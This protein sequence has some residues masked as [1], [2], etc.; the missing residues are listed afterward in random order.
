[1]STLPSSLFPGY[2]AVY[3]YPFKVFQVIEFLS[4][5]SDQLEL[6]LCLGF[7]WKMEVFHGTSFL[8]LEEKKLF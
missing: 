6:M 2:V 5:C 3:F 1:M 7:C 8:M 4:F